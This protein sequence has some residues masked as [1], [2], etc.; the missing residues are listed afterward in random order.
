[1]KQRGRW[2]ETEVYI[3]YWKDLTIICE[4]VNS[5]QDTL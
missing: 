4:V 3:Y 5:H 1:M 2:L